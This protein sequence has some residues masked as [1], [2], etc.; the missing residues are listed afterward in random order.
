MAQPVTFAN[1]EPIIK[2]RILTII[3]RKQNGKCHYCAKDFTVDDIIVSC[4]TRRRNYYHQVCAKR[5][6]II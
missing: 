6:N 1:D 3:K 2:R 4:G 5:L